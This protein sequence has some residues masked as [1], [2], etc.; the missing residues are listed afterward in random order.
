M[1]KDSLSTRLH[2]FPTITI[3]RTQ[4]NRFS[5]SSLRRRHPVR[6]TYEHCMSAMRFFFSR[7]FCQKKTP[8]YYVIL[9][10]SCWASYVWTKYTLTTNIHHVTWQ[11]TKI[12]QL[13]FKIFNILFKVKKLKKDLQKEKRKK[14]KN[15]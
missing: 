4:I 9:F 1:Q 5:T 7:L 10:L 12:R 6:S 2:F 15:T 8:F 14:K 13:L 11:W 3:Y